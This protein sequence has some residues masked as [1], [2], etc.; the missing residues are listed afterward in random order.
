MRLV[1]DPAR[2]E[3]PRLVTRT[4][5]L[6]HTERMLGWAAHRI[7]ELAGERLAG[8]LFKAKSPSSGLERVK[9][10]PARGGIAS[11]TGV[12]LFAGA[13]MARF[14]LLPVEDE[15][16]LHDPGLRENFIERVFALARWQAARERILSPGSGGLRHL[17]DFHARHKLLVM[18]HSPAHYRELG[19]LV[20]HAAGQPLA[21][22]LGVLDRYA[23]L[24]MAGLARKATPAKHV[25]TLMHVL[26]YFRRQIDDDEKR[27][28]LEV[29]EE[30]R[31]GKVPLIVPVTLANHYVRK[32]DQ[33]YLREQVYLHPHPAELKLRNHV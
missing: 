32:Y 29:L 7:D 22:D 27:E 25:N 18:S 28:F 15:G 24:L 6:D 14:P 20:A 19:P 5:G 2:P 33:P 23:A 8:F 9:V 1:A 17:V 21:G 30:Y 12:G 31:A 11:M 16:R 13:F 10:Y 3:G 4:T 26:G